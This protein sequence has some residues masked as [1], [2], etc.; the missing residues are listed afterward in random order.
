MKVGTTA[1]Q[2]AGQ[3]ISM[4]YINKKIDGVSGHY[5]V[6]ISSSRVST[7]HAIEKLPL[8]L[9]KQRLQVNLTVQHWQVFPHSFPAVLHNPVMLFAVD[10]IHHSAQHVLVR[11]RAKH[12]AVLDLMRV[13][14][15]VVCQHPEVPWR[16]HV[17][18]VSEAGE[19]GRKRKHFKL[20]EAQIRKQ[21]VG[22]W[23]GFDCC[24]TVCT[25]YYNPQQ[26]IT[27]GYIVVVNHAWQFLIRFISA[28]PSGGAVWVGP[29][30]WDSLQLNLENEKRRKLRPAANI[31]L[32]HMS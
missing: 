18:E 22:R 3:V 17:G 23:G 30:R 13:Q 8:L 26:A 21:L 20:K 9:L 25:M 10:M 24:L 6:L 1:R 7:M 31:L 12:P 2:P 11:D 14:L 19:V 16:N 4:F 27:E 15:E 29:G 28:A 5:S 32:H